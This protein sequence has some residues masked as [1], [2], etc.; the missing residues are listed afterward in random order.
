MTERF[1]RIGVPLLLMALAGIGPGCIGAPAIRQTRLKYNDAV[2][3]TTDEQILVNIVRLRYADSPV[4]LDLPNIT[5]QF[6]LSGRGSFLGGYGNQYPGQANLG[7]GE[8]ALRDSPTLSFQPR[9]GKDFGRT[10]AQPLTVELLRLVVNTTNPEPFFLMAVDDMNDIENAPEAT[11]LVPDH[12]E[13]NADFRS[14]MGLITA[15]RLKRSVELAVD[16]FE[17]E[18]S[19]PIPEANVGGTSALEAARAGFVYRAKGRDRAVLKKR[20]KTLALKIKREARNAPE[21]LEFER[22]LGLVPGQEMYRFRS[23]LYD[24]EDNEESFGMLPNP[25]GEDTIYLKMRSMLEIMTF[26]SKGVEIPPEHVARRIAPITC[27]PVTGAV[28][29]WSSVT[30]GLLRV[31]WH[32]TRPKDAE[33]AVPYRGYW[34]SIAED[35][36]ASRATL[37]TVEL[38][39]TLQESGGEE[40]GPVLTLPVSN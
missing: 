9:T 27:D 19:D 4:F 18:A 24:D 17:V 35:D 11:A 22:R 16:A 26:L 8:F 12:P 20:Q 38:L 1:R 3:T 13:D 37:A 5:S 32:K 15:F 14:L 31:R 36:V 7:N 23:E 34:F 40:L 10:L 30:A 33:V 6:E 21:L 39:L 25:L 2:R 29:D 28:Y